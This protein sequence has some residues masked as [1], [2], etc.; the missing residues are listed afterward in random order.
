MKHMASADE[1]SRLR[2]SSTKPLLKRQ[3]AAITKAG[4]AVCIRSD[5]EVDLDIRKVY[6]VISDV[7]ANTHGL[8]RVIDESGE[9]Y[10]YP[11]TYF[12]PLPLSR[13]S[14]RIV[15]QLD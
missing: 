12:L 11:A 3:A 4:H 14:A 15:N 5:G 13:R 7:D 2:G 9:D 10:L 6:R 8:V 1:T